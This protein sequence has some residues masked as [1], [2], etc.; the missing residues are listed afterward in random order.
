MTKNDESSIV[1][2]KTGM[3]VKLYNYYCGYDEYTRQP[4]DITG[5]Y[6]GTGREAQ[7]EFYE[8]AVIKDELG[9][10]GFVERYLTSDFFISPLNSS[11]KD[12]LRLVSIDTGEDNG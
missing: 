1:G 12:K 3:L 7:F 6:L 2:L 11:R 4:P 8:I 10:G 9:K 5:L